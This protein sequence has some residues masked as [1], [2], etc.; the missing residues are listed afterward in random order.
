MVRWRKA[1]EDARAQPLLSMDDQKILQKRHQE[2]QRQ[3]KML[4]Q[5]LRRNDRALAEAE[6]LLIA[7]KKIQ[8]YWAED[9]GN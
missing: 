6:A 4:Q 8:A 3:N 7:S 1:A 2:D 9:E 5:E